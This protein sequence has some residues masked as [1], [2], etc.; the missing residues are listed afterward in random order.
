MSVVLVCDIEECGDTSIC[1]KILD[2][3]KFPTMLSKE[4]KH[5][6]HI[7]EDCFLDYCER[8]K[9]LHKEMGCVLDT[10][11]IEYPNWTITQKLESAI[12]YWEKK[13]LQ[14]VEYWKSISIV[15]IRIKYNS[16]TLHSVKYIVK[17]LVE[18]GL[19]EENCNGDVKIKRRERVI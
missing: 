4:F 12:R 19:L 14:L 16:L 11:N 7:C 5:I 1:V 3:A 9:R 13:I 18:Q 15:S 10:N 2:T 8:I 6:D 17:N